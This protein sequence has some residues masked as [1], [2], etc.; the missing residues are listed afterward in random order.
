MTLRRACVC[1]D[2]AVLFVPKGERSGEVRCR[3]C[4]DLLL[5]FDLTPEFEAA[6]LASEGNE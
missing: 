4:N 3:D 1:H 6:Q 2:V 5:T